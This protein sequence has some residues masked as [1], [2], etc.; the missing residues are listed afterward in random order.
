MK[1]LAAALGLFG[2]L[3]LTSAGTGCHPRMAGTV[4]AAA[5]IT[6]AIVGTATVLQ[7]HD[8]HYHHADCGHHRRYHE[9]HWVYHY[10][11]RWEYYDSYESRWYY[12]A[13]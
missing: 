5:A 13:D 1:K 10:N 9:G 6:A 2:V 12:Y 8:G 11:G 4:I 3:S 7:H